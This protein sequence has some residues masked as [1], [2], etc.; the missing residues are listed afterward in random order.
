LFTPPVPFYPPL[1]GFFPYAL[2][3]AAAFLAHSSP[4]QLAVLL[5]SALVTFAGGYLYLDPIY[6]NRLFVWDSVWLVAG[7]VPRFAFAPAL[8]V[9]VVL[10]VRRL[11]GLYEKRCAGC[12]FSR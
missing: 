12:E 11:R 2:L 5:V 1:W 7:F 9:F 3:V 4:E 10:A 6:F 8:A